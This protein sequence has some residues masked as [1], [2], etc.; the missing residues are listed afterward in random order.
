MTLPFAEYP[1]GVAG[2]VVRV[3]DWPGA[4]LEAGTAAEP[5]VLL[6]H[7]LGSH[8]GVWREVGSR[9]AASGARAIAVDLPGHGLSS[10]GGDFEY[11]LDG[12]LRWL[13]ALLDALRLGR[14]ELVHLV[15]S[16]LGGLWAAGFATHRPERIATLTLVGAIGLAPLTPERRAWT[17]EYLTRMDRAS[18]A[19]RL[20]QAVHDPSVIDAALIESAYRMN[21]SPGAAEAFTALG[22]YYLE[23]LNAD[24]QLERLSALGT[25]TRVLLLWGAEDHIVPLE[26]ARAA[27]ARL[28]ASALLVL[29]GVGHIPQLE[30]PDAVAR[31]LADHVRPVR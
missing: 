12:H 25:R 8:A 9:L 1:L 19:S 7:G 3:I 14:R 16:S 2:T 28:G 15:G 5:T 6:V 22:R 10:K 23:S 31:A 4:G 24:V 29:E 30:R 18:I 26:Q 20:R 17:A 13:D 27:A 11:T 21:N